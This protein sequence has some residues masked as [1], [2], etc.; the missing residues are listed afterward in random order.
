MVFVAG[1]PWNYCGG[2]EWHVMSISPMISE[3][4]ADVGSLFYAYCSQTFHDIVPGQA[5]NNGVFTY[6]YG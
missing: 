5:K 4:T 2:G 6:W 3:V 1:Y